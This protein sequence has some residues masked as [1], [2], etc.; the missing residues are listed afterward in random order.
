MP[1]V[2]IPARQPA[3]DNIVA[4]LIP[5]DARPDTFR[6]G[7]IEVDPARHDA[8]R[9]SD[10][11]GVTHEAVDLEPDPEDPESLL[12]TLIIE[13]DKSSEKRRVKMKRLVQ[14]SKPYQ[15]LLVDHKKETSAVIAISA[16]AVTSL[17]VR[18][19]RKS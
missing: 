17:I 4:A 16:V 10:S 5:E 19:R 8:V 9:L 13:D 15:F 11:E 18:R 3:P 7:R 6:A 14:E 1:E 12:G 2:P